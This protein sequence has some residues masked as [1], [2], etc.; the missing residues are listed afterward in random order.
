[1]KKKIETILIGALFGD[2]DDELIVASFQS[3]IDLILL[4]KDIFSQVPDVVYVPIE[5]FKEAEELVGSKVGLAKDFSDKRQ[6]ENSDKIEYFKNR[7][8]LI[9][10]GIHASAFGKMNYIYRSKGVRIYLFKKAGIKVVAPYCTID[11]DGFQ[12]RQEEFI[13]F[14]FSRIK[15]KQ[16]VIEILGLT[17][18]NLNKKF[19]SSLAIQTAIRLITNI[20]KSFYRDYYLEYLLTPPDVDLISNFSKNVSFEMW[21]V[22]LS[23]EFANTWG[24]ELQD[25]C[26]NLLSTLQVSP[27]PGQL[28]KFIKSDAQDEG[29]K[30]IIE[31]LDRLEH[32]INESINST[33][34]KKEPIF[35]FKPNFNGIGI[36]GNEAFRRLKNMWTKKD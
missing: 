25:Q 9:F 32:N 19:D 17:R 21:E 10:D 2:V 33:K 23:N 31:R 18:E 34:E 16:D 26:I 3:F 27:S 29:T 7:G 22:C 6:I 13:S 12:F 15:T 4:G 35:E 11:H 1:M 5:K 36:N 30:K 8:A 14:P 28:I 20:K 24:K